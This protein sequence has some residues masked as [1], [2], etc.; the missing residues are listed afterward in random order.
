MRAYGKA[1]ASI[2]ISILVCGCSSSPAQSQR[3]GQGQD[4]S[5]YVFALYDQ[6]SGGA[7]TRLLSQV[8]QSGQPRPEPVMRT[9][10]PVTMMK[11]TAMAAT[12]VIWRNRAGVTIAV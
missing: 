3:T 1:L 12:R 5:R 6:P 8:G 11:A 9:A 4:Y 2:P 10:P 7:T